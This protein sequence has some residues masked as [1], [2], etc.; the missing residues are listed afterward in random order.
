MAPVYELMSSATRSLEM[1]MYELDDP[2]AEQILVSD[3]RRGVAVRV[4]LDEDY[5]GRSVN[6]A[7]YEEFQTGGV[8]VR[9]AN[10]REIFH[11][12]TITV[13]DA[14][15]A[16]MTANLTSRYYSTTRD[17][18]VVDRQ[19]QDVAA[20]EQVFSEDFAGGEPSEA[21]A[22]QDLV[23]SPGSE[24]PLSS[25]ITSATR[26]VICENEEMDSPYIESALEADARRGVD[27][28]VVMTTDSSYDAAFRALEAAGVHVVLY[29]D[30]SSA[31]YI[32]AKAIDVDSARAFLGS[33]NFSD[34]SLDYNRELGIITSS[35]AVLGPLN[36][37]LDGDATGRASP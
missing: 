9:W 18:I 37:V 19:P 32:H 27:V 5:E 16:I 30:T 29:P 28:T 11:Q 33:E 31:L 2:T 22:G 14:T 25:L 7:A 4:L 23:W 17:L 1:T 24:G 15:S 34:A 3:A 20:I 12:K 13:D 6:R 35:A 10:D 36:S 21:P 8:A 26:S